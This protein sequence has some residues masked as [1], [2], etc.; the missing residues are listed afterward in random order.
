MPSPNP[1]TARAPYRATASDRIAGTEARLGR[2][3]MSYAELP[4]D[5]CRIVVANRDRRYALARIEDYRND[6]DR[7]HQLFL[8]ED[9]ERDAREYIVAVLERIRA[10]RATDR[11]LAGMIRAADACVERTDALVHLFHDAATERAMEKL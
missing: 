4:D 5:L 6:P 1:D 9:A 2:K 3:I 11:A 8:A 7:E 10:A